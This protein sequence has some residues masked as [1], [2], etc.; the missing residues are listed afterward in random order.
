M[1][2]DWPSKESLMKIME[3]DGMRQLEQLGGIEG[4]MQKLHTSPHGIS[5]AELKESERTE[6]YST[7]FIF[8]L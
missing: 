2:S 8:S 7:L 3:E 1:S 6:K 5:A 4:I